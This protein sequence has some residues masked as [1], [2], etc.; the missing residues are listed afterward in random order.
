MECAG[1]VMKA[2]IKSIAQECNLSITAVSLVLNGK[3]NR[4]SAET[5]KLIL[6]TAKK[7]N[8]SPNQIAVGLVKG[9]TST[10]GL[11]LSDISNLFLAEIAKIVEEEVK[12]YKYTVIF[13]NTGDS[14]QRE[15]EYIEEFLGKNVD[16]IILLHSSY[17][18]ESEEKRII[19]LVQ[20]SGVPFVMLDNDI[21]V[22]EIFR[23]VLDNEK[24]GY[25]AGTHLFELGHRKVGCLLGPMGQC[26]VRDR[27]KGYKK[28]L[29]DWRIPF[30]EELLYYGDFTIQSGVMAMPYFLEKQVTAVFSYNDMMTYG[31]YTYAREHNIKIGTDISIIGFDDCF[32]N[33]LLEI[34]LTS[35]KQPRVE[36]TRKATECLISLIDGN[37][38]KKN[39]IVF[40][41]EL[42]VRSSTGVKS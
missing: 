2:T 12:K 5:K 34:P 29:A 15:I 39:P 13:G 30:E 9:K 41:P 31:L 11:I 26:S 32:I 35:M 33:N 7:Q 22:S 6:E 25:L 42:V 18:T 16:G 17:V 24:G 21:T 14:G 28:A 20:R 8:Y 23:C 27:L 36:M 19:E 40:D 4:I 3:P 38:M 1:E 37:K 10:I